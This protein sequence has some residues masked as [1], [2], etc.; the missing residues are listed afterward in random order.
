MIIF[1]QNSDFQSEKVSLISQL[2]NSSTTSKFFSIISHQSINS[3]I[4]ILQFISKFFFG[5]LGDDCGNIDN[6][7]LV[8]I[9]PC[10]ANRLSQ[11]STYLLC[12]S[13]NKA[14]TIDPLLADLNRLGYGGFIKYYSVSK[15]KSV[16]SKWLYLGNEAILTPSW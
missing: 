10:I 16:K 4:F 8:H 11:L 14:M 7:V 3:I 12:M 2:V 13:H 5:I 15:I 6:I 9:F 1:N